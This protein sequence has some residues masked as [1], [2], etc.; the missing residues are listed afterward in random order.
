MKATPEEVLASLRADIKKNKIKRKHLAFILGFKTEQA[1]TNLLNSKRYLNTK[2]AEA[3]S[4]FNYNPL[5]LTKG[6]GEMR[7]NINFDIITK[8]DDYET[9][10]KSLLPLNCSPLVFDDNSYL[11]YV[12]Q[13]FKEVVDLIQD[14]NAIAICNELIDFRLTVQR[15]SN[16]VVESVAEEDKEKAVEVAYGLHL[17]RLFNIFKLL[18]D[19]NVTYIKDDLPIRTYN[20]QEFCKLLEYIQKRYPLLARVL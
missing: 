16:S 15:I 13:K 11:V 19:D 2:Q 17:P 10:I 6:L 4:Y 9:K 12:L 18:R 8:Q 5:Y 14:P 7:T 20:W 1:V 3:L